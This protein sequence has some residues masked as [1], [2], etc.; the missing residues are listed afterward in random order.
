M[1]PTPVIGIC[2][3][4]RTG[5]DTVTDFL[6][7][8]YGGYRY[9]FAQ[10]LKAMLKAGF[11]MDLESTYWQERKEEV[12]PALG[13]SPRE[14]MQTLGTEWGRRLVHPE[15]WLILGTGVLNSRGAGMI[16]S[17]VRFENEAAWVRKMGGKVIHLERANAPQVKEHVSEAGVVRQPEDIQL[18]N[19]GSLEDLQFAISRL[20]SP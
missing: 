3:R 6:I 17:D 10:P 11:G 8:Q 5:K 18:F 7:A 13:R 16:V 14:L 15:L 20:F 2:G 19:N 4:A 1:R 12:I 9:S